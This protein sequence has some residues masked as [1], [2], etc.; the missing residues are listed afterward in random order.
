MQPGAIER[1]PQAYISITITDLNA[2]GAL[3]ITVELTVAVVLVSLC[4]CHRHKRFALSLA[5][6]RPT[7]FGQCLIHIA[8]SPAPSCSYFGKHWMHVAIA[9]KVALPGRINMHITALAVRQLL[10]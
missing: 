5:T 6:L 1:Q 10:R 9:N 7:M 2:A 8:A 4:L 3:Q